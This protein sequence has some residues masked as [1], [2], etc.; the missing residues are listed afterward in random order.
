[1][2]SHT[3]T[4]CTIEQFAAKLM[5]KSYYLCVEDFDTKNYTLEFSGRSLTVTQ[6]QFDHGIW[7]DIVRN[8]FQ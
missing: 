2:K 4:C 8:A 3:P 6:Q 1:M 7:Q 5:P